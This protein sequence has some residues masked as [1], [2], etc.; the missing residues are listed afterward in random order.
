MLIR[1]LIFDFA[2]GDTALVSKRILR[3]RF[4]ILPSNI[5][6]AF[7]YVLISIDMRARTFFY[8]LGVDSEKVLASA[9]PGTKI[10][11]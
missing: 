6:P 9:A 5:R 10:Q 2:D 4:D 3:R 7:R 1:L 8:K 11:A